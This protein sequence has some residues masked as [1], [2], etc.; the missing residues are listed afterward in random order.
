MEL[1]LWNK[2]FIVATE[3][4]SYVLKCR[5]T[6]KWHRLSIPKGYKQ[7]KFGGLKNAVNGSLDFILKSLEMIPRVEPYEEWWV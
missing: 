1:H 6:F 3:M 7:I 5:E 4:Y 2:G